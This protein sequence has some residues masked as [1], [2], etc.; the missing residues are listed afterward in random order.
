MHPQL[1]AKPLKLVLSITVKQ[2]ISAL[3]S[4]LVSISQRIPALQRPE[5]LPRAV[6]ARRWVA[7]HAQRFL[8]SPEVGDGCDI[9][10]N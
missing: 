5:V 2:R 10:A 3:V 7:I 8:L 1:S 6:H 4:I 9:G